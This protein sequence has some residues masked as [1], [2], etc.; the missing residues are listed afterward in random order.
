MFDFDFDDEDEGTWGFFDGKC[1]ACDLYGRVDD[2]SLCQTCAGKFERDMIRQRNW[3]YSALAFGLP[4]KD[5][6]KL[7]QQIIAQYGE[8]LEMLAPSEEAGDHRGK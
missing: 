2:I 1:Q 7:R 5:H 6:E 3:D 8:K 4:D